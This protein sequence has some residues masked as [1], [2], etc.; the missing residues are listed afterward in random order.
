[1]NGCLW[2]HSKPHSFHSHKEHE[3]VD[4]L[5]SCSRT[6]SYSSFGYHQLSPAAMRFVLQTPVSN[7]AQCR[8]EKMPSGVYDKASTEADLNGCIKEVSSWHL[9][10]EQNQLVV[11]SASYCS[12]KMENALGFTSVKNVLGAICNLECFISWLRMAACTAEC[13]TSFREVM[14]VNMIK[15]F[16]SF[17]SFTSMSIDIICHWFVYGNCA[18]Y[19]YSSSGGNMFA[20]A[21]YIY[22]CHNIHLT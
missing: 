6:P 9:F 8:R 20:N 3:R 22:F 1:M 12:R 15:G 11:C 16:K 5:V 4:M 17:R 10:P 19:M 7:T 2:F 13:L 21:N 14:S 18:C